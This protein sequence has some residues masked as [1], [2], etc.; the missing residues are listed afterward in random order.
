MADLLVDA[1]DSYE[2][3]LRYGLS[4]FSR[5]VDLEKNMLRLRVAD[6][7]FWFVDIPRTS[8]TFIKNNLAEKIGYPFGKSGTLLDFGV[9]S[10][11]SAAYSTLLP[12]H[13][14]AFCV[15][16][17]FG[18]ELWQ[19]IV[20]VSVVR[21]PYE[22]CWS[23]WRYV[24]ERKDLGFSRGSFLSFLDQLENKIIGPVLTRRS[25]PTDFIQSDYILDPN[26][27]EV[28]VKRVIH[29][30]DRDAVMGILA[31]F[32][33]TEAGHQGAM[34][35]KDRNFTLSATEKKVVHRICARDFDLFG[36]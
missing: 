1:I 10:P 36:Y 27:S 11:R 2:S 13:T 28:L 8:S 18:D 21:N 3:G 33:V 22:W 35:S 12:D 31:E 26:N 29:F 15:R 19:D 16:E 14:P 20:T 5:A 30:E 9:K 17:I 7:G 4:H 32:G 25:Y 23:L 34:A 24:E 6:L